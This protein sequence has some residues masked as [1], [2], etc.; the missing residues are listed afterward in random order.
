MNC[1]GHCKN[2]RILLGHNREEAI[3]N[4]FRQKHSKETS[5]FATRRSRTCTLILGWR[6]ITKSQTVL[7]ASSF[8]VFYA[9][10]GKEAV[11][12]APSKCCQD[13]V[14]SK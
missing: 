5:P 13:R 11:G 8:E 3:V 7:L 9:I 14:S 12:R 6:H 2:P 1:S 10:S 4:Q